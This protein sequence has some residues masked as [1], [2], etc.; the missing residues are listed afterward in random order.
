MGKLEDYAII[1][2]N[3]GLIQEQIVALEL[4]FQPNEQLVENPSL[5]NLAKDWIF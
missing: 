1:S 5:A 3:L 4:R 2:P